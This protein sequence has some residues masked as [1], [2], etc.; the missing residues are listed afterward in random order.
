[1]LIAITIFALPLSALV[2]LFLR[3]KGIR[4]AYIWLFLFVSVFATFAI[5]TLAV[6]ENITPFLLPNFFLRGNDSISIVFRLS[7]KNKLIGLGLFTAM[8]VY[9]ATDSALPRGNQSLFHWVE[10]LI[11]GAA[12]WLAMLAGNAW[13][14]LIA[15]TVV[16]M[17][18]L[19]HDFVF[20]RR[21]VN[22]FL[23]FYLT[24]FF[25]SMILVYLISRTYLS[26]PQSILGDAIPNLGAWL[27]IAIFLH[28]GL[29]FDPSKSHSTSEEKLVAFLKYSGLLSN[30]F[31][32]TQISFAG[33]SPILELIL[34]I[35]FSLAAIFSAWKWNIGKNSQSNLSYFFTSI[36][37]IAGFM[38][39]TSNQ[40][41][42][43]FFLLSI[44]NLIW[45]F[46]YTERSK[47]LLVIAFLNLISLSGLLYTINYAAY[48]YFL[49]GNQIINAIT[50]A[51]TTALILAGIIHFLQMPGGK[52]DSLDNINQAVYSAG[53]LF[54]IGVVLFVSVNTFKN[55]N[56]IYAWPGILQIALSIGLFI[57]FRKYKKDEVQST[58]KPGLGKRSHDAL[59][60]LERT[61]SASFRLLGT[62]LQ[63]AAR[64]F[65]AEGGI[66]WSIVFLSLLISIISALGGIS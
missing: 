56:P 38:F 33:I 5:V 35:G 48:H 63:F 66:L 54:P 23:P 20:R 61:F 9:L 31:L 25:G 12:S 2:A 55:L 19:I 40:L 51:I 28:A 3:F 17:V 7:E 27:F 26:Q 58:G 49:H 15:W 62:G 65:E 52:F 29:M 6:P 53:L 43:Q 60:T 45:L 32:L 41:G 10:V 8:L 30:L 4:L 16:D 11:N 46:F 34:K 37:F 22:K 44:I 14:L 36:A 57:L 64:L 39:V 50:F 24:K 21:P 47:G 18:S 1:M 42:L 59:S 13:T